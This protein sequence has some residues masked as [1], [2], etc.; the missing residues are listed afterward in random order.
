MACLLE[1]YDR[2]G[3][4]I[5]ENLAKLGLGAGQDVIRP[6]DNPV[7]PQDISESLKGT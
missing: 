6:V 5:A 3:K 1:L 2:H 4:T 7:K